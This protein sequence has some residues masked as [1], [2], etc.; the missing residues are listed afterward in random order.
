[1]FVRLDVQFG[2]EWIR[3]TLGEFQ[4]SSEFV[5]IGRVS[6]RSFAVPNV[7]LR[8]FLPSLL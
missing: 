8:S 3:G 7:L 2:V 5:G 4:S 1:M 6:S